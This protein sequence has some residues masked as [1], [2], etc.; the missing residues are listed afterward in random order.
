MGPV[1]VKG[2]RHHSHYARTCSYF[3]NLH[4]TSSQRHELAMVEWYD[5]NLL[6]LLV[7]VVPIYLLCNLPQGCICVLCLCGC[8]VFMLLAT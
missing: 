8:F 7:I 3:A 6:L 1:I 5:R 2:G 4:L